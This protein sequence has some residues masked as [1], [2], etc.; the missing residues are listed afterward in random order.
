MYL[1]QAIMKYHYLVVFIRHHSAEI[2]GFGYG[3]TLGIGALK[4]VNVWLQSRS[5]PARGRV[6]L[7]V[8]RCL[9]IID[10]GNVFIS[11]V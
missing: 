3:L 9:C 4:I 11:T 6:G 1:H 2:R 7:E 5:L 10:A 8:H